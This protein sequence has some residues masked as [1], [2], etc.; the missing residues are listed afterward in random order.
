M[1]TKCRILNC[2]IMILNWWF[3][4]MYILTSNCNFDRFLLL[5][6][7]FF[8]LNNTRFWILVWLINLSELKANWL[9][10]RFMPT[11]FTKV[12]GPC[13]SNVRYTL[14]S[15]LIDGKTMK[16]PRLNIGVYTGEMIIVGSVSRYQLGIGQIWD[17][18]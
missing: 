7:S 9:P 17:I 18:C 5:H 11:D 16:K 14:I 13:S 1:R 6:I 8:V 3:S 2:L 15:W 12:L 10:I 4:Y